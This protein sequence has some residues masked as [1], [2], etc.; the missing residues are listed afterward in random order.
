MFWEGKRITVARIHSICHRM[1]VPIPPKA[2]LDDP[3]KPVIDLIYDFICRNFTKQGTL[4]YLTREQ[5][6]GSN[7]DRFE[8]ATETIMG[9]TRYVLKNKNVKKGKRG[10]GETEN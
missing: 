6:I 5:V 3:V 1:N 2:I 4:L 8:V 10:K 9:V 7:I